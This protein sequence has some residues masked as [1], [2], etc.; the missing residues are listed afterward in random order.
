MRRLL[1]RCVLGVVLAVAAVSVARAAPPDPAH[2]ALDA[3]LRRHVAW[4]AAGTA[5]TSSSVRSWPVCGAK[6]SAAR[7]I[8]PRR[9]PT[10]NTYWN[11]ARAR[12][13]T[14][15]WAGGSP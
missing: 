8:V 13:C 14:P 15:L 5:S 7:T 3:L 11:M 4:N 12:R 10:P 6:P 1:V 9:W 2:A